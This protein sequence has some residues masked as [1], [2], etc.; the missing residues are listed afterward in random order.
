MRDYPDSA[1]ARDCL[2]VVRKSAVKN[3]EGATTTRVTVY[4]DDDGL[5]GVVDGFAELQD[6]NL[7]TENPIGE[8][9]K[10]ALNGKK[11]RK[12]YEE[13]VR[14]WLGDKYDEVMRQRR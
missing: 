5:D 7:Y 13:A 1:A 3:K 6:I 4:V 9:R 12:I 2:L 10:E 11:A 14:A 8:A